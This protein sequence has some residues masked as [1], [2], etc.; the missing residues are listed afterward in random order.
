MQS[1][2]ELSLQRWILDL[3]R[4]GEEVHIVDV[5]ANKGQWSGAMIDA[6]RQAG[7]LGDLD[8]HAFEP[9]SYTFAR[10]SEALDG[11]RVSLYRAALGDRSGSATLHVIAP[12]AGTNSLY[13]APGTP[14]GATTENVATTTLDSFAHG[15]ELEHLT[16]VKIDT[17]GHDLAVLRGARTL[18][19]DQR[20]SVAQ[21]EYNHRWIYARFFLRDAFEMLEPLGYRIGKL[22]PQGLEFYPDWDVDLE[23]FIEGNYVAC[24]SHIAERLPSVIWWKA[25]S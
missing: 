20:I 10:L 14:D 16:M 15:A 21:F 19:A 18:F 8:L 6:A 4:P 11:Q 24:A 5:G 2:G 9:S 7:R 1:N 25:V 23:M 22:T 17:E 3:S 13:K 12:A